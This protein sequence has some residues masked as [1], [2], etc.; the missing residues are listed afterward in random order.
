MTEERTIRNLR[1]GEAAYTVAHAAWLA[2][3]HMM[4]H[5]SMPIRSEA[6]GSFNLRLVKFPDGHLA[7]DVSETGGERFDRMPAFAGRLDPVK[8]DSCLTPPECKPGAFRVID[9]PREGVGYMR[10]TDAWVFDNR[11][12]LNGHTELSREP[13]EEYSLRIT[14]LWGSGAYLVDVSHVGNPDYPA[15]APE[16]V[17]VFPI[18]VLKATRDHSDCRAAA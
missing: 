16:G 9:L 18:Q 17:S 6:G 12:F 1:P 7:V 15:Y 3:E 14:R 4:L 10:P 5:G 11:M 8:V 13:S 2:G